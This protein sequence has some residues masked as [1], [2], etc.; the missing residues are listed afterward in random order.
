[1][2]SSEQIAEAVED[3]NDKFLVYDNI[4]PKIRRELVTDFLL[5]VERTPDKK[6]L[7]SL[8]K[9]KS[10]A[11]L[12][13]EKLKK[14]GETEIRGNFSPKTRKQ[15]ELEGILCYK[16]KGIW[17]ACIAEDKMK[18]ILDSGQKIGDKYFCVKRYSKLDH[19]IKKCFLENGYTVDEQ[20]CYTTGCG[21][22]DAWDPCTC[23]ACRSGT[24][25]YTGSYEIYFKLK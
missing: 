4:K 14:E 5:N 2:Q 24:Q 6:W 10:E 11:E 17:V 9:P 1:M 12:V 7:V 23:H 18:S 15:L 13:V 25:N 20:A 22:D 16:E 19:N 21:Y 8:D 3:S